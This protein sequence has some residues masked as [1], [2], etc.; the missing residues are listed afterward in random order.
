[1]APATVA[2]IKIAQ[3]NSL[4]LV[5]L[6]GAIGAVIGDLVI[7]YFLRDHLTEDFLE[8]LKHGTS[9]KRIR[10]IFRSKIMRFSLAIIGALVIASPLPDEL[11]L[12]LLGISKIKSSLFIPI[13]FLMNFLGIILINV[14]A[15]LL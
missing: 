11:G 4:W 1:M 13:S 5:A 15:R 12:A 7:F 6:L 8:L 10:H 2:L 3:F 14:V 9:G